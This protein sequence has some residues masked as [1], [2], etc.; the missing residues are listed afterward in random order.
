MTH[1]NVCFICEMI[2]HITIG[3]E[4]SNADAAKLR[5]LQECI[6]LV[7]GVCSESDSDYA[8]NSCETVVCIS[9]SN[10]CTNLQFKRKPN[11]VKQ[12]PQERPSPI[13]RPNLEQTKL[14]DDRRQPCT[15]TKP[16]GLRF[17]PKKSFGLSTR[18]SRSPP[19]SRLLIWKKPAFLLTPR[20]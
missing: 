14:L 10:G 15:C 17:R 5:H 2:E 3:I 16:C 8:N 13:T 4:D 1:C 7:F 12:A 18:P 20:S 19:C 11:S 9:S 6:E